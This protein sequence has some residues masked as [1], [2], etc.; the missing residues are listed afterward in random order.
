MRISWT[1][2]G[3][4]LRAKVEKAG[5][6]LGKSHSRKMSTTS[7]STAPQGYSLSEA[8]KLA[9]KLSENLPPS[10][11]DGQSTPMSGNSA[12]SKLT[13]EQKELLEP[14]SEL[15][16][17]EIREENAQESVSEENVIPELTSSSSRSLTV[18]NQNNSSLHLSV[19]DEDGERKLYIHADT[20]F[21]LPLAAFRRYLKE[22]TDNDDMAELEEQ[23]RAEFD[24]IVSVSMSISAFLAIG[25]SVWLWYILAG[26]RTM[27]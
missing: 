10:D 8:R 14:D 12:S 20:A 23:R 7:S 21:T 15:E 1:V 2:S 19:Y 22:V 3:S 6:V 25:F 13:P 26:I 27:S 24:T 5:R 11:S 17:G 18:S 4:A 16:E 9:E